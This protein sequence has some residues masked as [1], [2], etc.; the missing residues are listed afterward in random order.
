M[1][2]IRYAG[3]I[4][5]TGAQMRPTAELNWS[6]GRPVV[7]AS[8][9]MGVPIE[10]KATGAVLARRQRHAAQNGEKP[11]PASIAA[12]T[13]TGVPNPAAPSMNAPNAKATS[14]ACM[15]RSLEKLPME[16]FTISN[17]PVTWVMRNKR[18]AVK[19]TQPMG[20][21]PNAAP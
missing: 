1:T 9:K 2:P 21:S 8:V 16:C 7:A 5:E 12:A 13:A 15:R 3:T 18:I 19:T 4:N 10:P 17:L 20:N 14:S 11:M 6:S